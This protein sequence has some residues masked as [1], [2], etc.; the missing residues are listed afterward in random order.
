MARAKQSKAKDSK[1]KQTVSLTP[2]A[3]DECLR[4]SDLLDQIFRFVPPSSES[5][6]ADMNAARKTLYSAA[7]ISRTFSYSALKVL[8]HRLD[9]LLPLLRLLSTFK[10][11]GS[12]YVLPGV[13]DDAAWEVFDRHAAYVRE[14]LYQRS[15]PVNP[16][17]YVR[18]AMHKAVLLPNLSRFDC[19]GA[20]L[21]P[22]PDLVLF[23]SPL[24]VSL[25]LEAETRSD[26]DPETFLNMLSV[27]AAP[28]AHLTLAN[29]PNS[30]LSSCTLFRKLQSIN[31]TSLGG[32]V[33]TSAFHDLGSL[34][35]LESLTT[36]LQGWDKVNFESITPGSMFRALT[37]LHI[38]GGT[39]GT[40]PLLLARIGSNSMVSI[41]VFLSHYYR[42]GKPDNS[43]DFAAI[44]ECISSRWPTTLAH[45]NLRGVRC[46]PEDFSALQGATKIQTLE[47]RQSLQ[48]SLTDARVLSIFRTWSELTSLTIDGAEADMEVL[49]CLAEHC[50][51]LRALHIAFFPDPL[52]ELSTT[53]VLVDL[54]LLARHLDRLF[55]QVVSIVGQ[56]GSHKWD[57]V[58]K[59]VSMCQ[60]VRR[61]AWDQK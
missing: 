18:L 23:T 47:L 7:L 54:H 57:E 28:L 2:S 19:P 58:A 44:A 48:G 40:I 52:P 31:L 15:A 27:V 53:P 50:T 1:S 49:I 41:S 56:G 43:E 14:I 3:Q 59:L 6:E 16:V 4:N 24:L 60:D 12:F 17:V 20:N 35:V 34:P 22:G 13:V 26:T 46:A 9:N 45:L 37:H 11:S 33:V 38:S 25:R 32:P 30:V 42:Y 10:R 51:A 55:P 36:D 61:T 5:G 29:Y 21:S 39:Q 8:W